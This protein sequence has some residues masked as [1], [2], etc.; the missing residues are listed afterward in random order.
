VA[1]SL[2][3]IV[4]EDAEALA[5]N[6]AGLIAQFIRANA[7]G[8]VTI[9]FAGGSTPAATY[10]AL[11]HEDV[12]WD[13][14][15]GW[16]GDERF[17]PPDHPDNNGTM[18]RTSLLDSTKATFFPVPWD[19]DAT[20]TEIAT[21]YE[22]TL[23]EVMSHDEHGPI[24]DLLLAGIGDDG[25][26]LSLFPGSPAL[27]VANRWFTENWVEKTESWRLTTT[28]PLAWRARQ[29]YVLVSGTGKAHALAAIGRG[30]DLPATRL[31]EHNENVTWLVDV[32]AAAEIGG[33]P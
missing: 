21:A 19:D 32:A 29:V 2:D 11:V 7:G 13:R 31:M 14:V 26:T 10:A 24:P 20:P 33:S 9:G 17:V 1:D 12:P 6:A 3:L 23:T 4:H 25:H 22:L 30:E 16:V 5:R 27:N 15:Y 28:Y 18:I 8:V